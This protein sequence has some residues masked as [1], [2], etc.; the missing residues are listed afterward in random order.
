MKTDTQTASF[1]FGIPVVAGITRMLTQ[2]TKMEPQGIQNSNCGSNKLL[3]S[4]FN[5]SAVA[6]RTKGAGGRGEA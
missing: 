6:S 5:V 3:I 4:A 1:L 2:D